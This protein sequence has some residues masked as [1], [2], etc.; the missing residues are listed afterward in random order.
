MKSARKKHRRFNPSFASQVKLDTKNP[1][2]NVKLTGFNNQGDATGVTEDGESIDVAFGIPEEDVQ[3]E[4]LGRR[5]S[6]LYGRVVKIYTPSN[7]RKLP[8]CPHFGECGGCQLQHIDYDKQLQLK[9]D[10]VIKTLR[11]TAKIV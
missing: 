9:R 1:I 10:I 7:S 6:T 2:I 8:E 4:I 5:E 11:Q 3:V